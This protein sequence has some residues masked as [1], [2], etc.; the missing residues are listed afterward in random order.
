MPHDK[1]AMKHASSSASTVDLTKVRPYGDT[2]DDG[3]VQLS[4]TLPVPPGPEAE[5]AA[6]SL[7]R[8]WGFREPAVVDTQDMQNGYTFFVAYG[9]SQNSVDYS[10]IQV[11]RAQT[12]LLNKEEVDARIAT[13]LNDRPLRV[14]GACTGSDAHTVGIDAI[15]NIKGINGHKG[16]ESYHGFE[17]QNLGAQVENSQ[18]L[19][20]ARA[21]DADAVLISQIVTQKNVHVQNLTEFI[22]MAEAEG[23]RDRLI[24]IVGGP[25]LSHELAMELGFDAGF[26]RGSYADD[27]ASFLAQRISQKITPTIAPATP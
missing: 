22:E 5:E 21:F 8:S 16:L 3:K 4:F 24:C 17:V 19:A 25:R 18:L 26:G 15:L 11:P 9:A 2:I 7:L 13:A 1:P 12:V 20:A 14:I 23:L 10:V 6:L 27:V